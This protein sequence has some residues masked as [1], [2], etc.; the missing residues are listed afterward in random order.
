MGVGCRV[1]ALPAMVV[2]LALGSACGGDDG[3]DGDG[4]GPSGVA[5]ALGVLPERVRGDDAIVVAYGDLDRATELAGAVR[6]DDAS[7]T[8]AV[9]DWM[10]EIGGGG[11]EVSLVLP[12][13]ARTGVAESEAVEDELG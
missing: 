4:G 1:R 7:D 6:P 11:D 13:D 12:S 9:V 5:G 2:L 10:M 3:D 8:E